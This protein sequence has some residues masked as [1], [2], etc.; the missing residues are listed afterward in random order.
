[1]QNT[2]ES[3][4]YGS[5]SIHNRKLIQEMQKVGRKLTI[6]TLNIFSNGLHFSLLAI[7]SCWPEQGSSSK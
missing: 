5:K 7:S 3:D 4:Y 1:M 2:L 6:I